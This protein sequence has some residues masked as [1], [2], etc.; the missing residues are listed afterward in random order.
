[1][2]LNYLKWTTVFGTKHWGH[3]EHAGEKQVFPA[4]SKEGKAR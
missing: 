3:T 4:V 2:M 1:M